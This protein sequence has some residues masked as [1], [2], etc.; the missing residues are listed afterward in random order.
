MTELSKELKIVLTINAI[1]A[2]FY[3]FMFLVIPDIY[4]ELSDEAYPNVNLLRLW[5]GTIGLLG[6]FA[7]ITVKRGEWEGGKIFIEF[8]IGW[9][10]I[11]TI[12]NLASLVYIPR[13]P[14][15]LASAWS[16]IIVTFVFFLIDLYFYQK[17]KKG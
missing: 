17:Q 3:A 8:A 9:L 13:S 10:L 14:T 7:L 16:D 5:G 11:V 4:H 2:F 6:V 12:I 15:A 1:A